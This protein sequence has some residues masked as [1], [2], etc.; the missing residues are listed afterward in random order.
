MPRV[1]LVRYATV[2]HAVAAAV[3]PRYAR[4]RSKHTYTQPQLLAVLLLMRYDGWTFRDAEVRLAEHAELRRALGFQGT[5]VP[6]YTT[7]WRFLDRLDLAVLDHGDGTVLLVA[8]VLPGG[9]YDDA[10][11]RLDAMATALS[12][13]APA[14]GGRSGGLRRTMISTRKMFQPAAASCGASRA[15]SCSSCITSLRCPKRRWT[16]SASS[17]S[18]STW[19]ALRAPMRPARRRSPSA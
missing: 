18:S 17:T 9:S 19:L 4:P 16:W 11:S 5:R 3:L 1:G 2:A 7:L 10:V 12:A 8:N 14:T 15:P 13:A 6:D